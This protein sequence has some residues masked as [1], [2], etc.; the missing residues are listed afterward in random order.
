VCRRV[1]PFHPLQLFAY[2]GDENDETFPPLQTTDVRY[3]GRSSAW[4][5]PTRSS[6]A[7]R[8]HTGHHDV[9]VENADN[10]VDGRTHDPVVA[11]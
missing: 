8:R 9:R 4:S 6:S 7:G 5:W 10:L 1:T 3:Y 11:P 2:G